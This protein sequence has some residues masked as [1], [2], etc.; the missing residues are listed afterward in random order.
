MSRHPEITFVT[1][2]K[3]LFLIAQ[4]KGLPWGRAKVRGRTK[5]PRLWEQ[6]D[7]GKETSTGG[8]RV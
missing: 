4:I 8:K 7:H 2:P 6:K 3:T 1:L 5:I